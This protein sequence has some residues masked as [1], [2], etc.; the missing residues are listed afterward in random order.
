MSSITSVNKCFHWQASNSEREE[1][2]K[3]EH[4]LK[5]INSQSFSGFTADVDQTICVCAP[6]TVQMFGRSGE[7]YC[8]HLQNDCVFK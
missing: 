8:L 6:Y 1:Q 5:K 3:E 2:E 7:I 4:K